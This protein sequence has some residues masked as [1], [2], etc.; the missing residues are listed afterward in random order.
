MNGVNDNAYW[1]NMASQY[2]RHTK[3]S[4]KMYERIIQLIQHEVFRDA[5]ILDIGTG[6]G[7]IPLSICHNVNNIEAIDCSKEMT[8]IASSK[9]TKQGIDN[10]TFRVYDGMQLPYQDKAFDIVIMS[11]LLHVIPSP[12]H[13]LAEVFR[14][15]KDQ[16]KIIL[17]TYLHNDS[18]RTRCISWILRQKG[19][20]VYARFSS[21][22]LKE[23]VEQNGFKVTSQIYLKN[24]MPASFIVSRKVVE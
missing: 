24:I 2:D 4:S 23:F 7:E 6:T 1:D 13:M 12:R 19:H 5:S 9:A 11:N 16:G 15:L 21:A 14:V 18:W 3:K 8:A 20:P 22:S 10:V 17:P